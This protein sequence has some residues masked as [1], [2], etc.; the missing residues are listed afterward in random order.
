M[1]SL[2]RSISKW[3]LKERADKKSNL[4]W[5]S[6]EMKSN[7]LHEGRELVWLLKRAG[8]LARQSLLILSLG[9]AVCPHLSATQGLDLNLQLSWG[10]KV[11]RNSSG[12]QVTGQP[13][14]TAMNS[15]CGPWRH[16]TMAFPLETDLAASSAWPFFSL[17]WSH[18]LGPL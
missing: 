8:A 6:L 7:S 1:W 2:G 4:T 3:R 10:L 5:S 14:V 9:M 17:R 16:I 12:S 15:L 13:R 18:R 11:E